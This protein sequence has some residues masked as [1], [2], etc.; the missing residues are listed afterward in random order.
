MFTVRVA[1]DEISAAHALPGY[2]GDC[3]RRHGHNWSFAAV[4]TASELHQDMVV[5][6]RIVKDVFRALDHTDLN[7]IPALNGPNCRPTA[8][9][10]A[11]YLA[12]RLE[13]VL[14]PLPNHPTLLAL[15]V[16]ETSRN[17]VTYQPDGA[18][19]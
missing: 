16:R 3:A 13:G 11:Q 6:F 14:A 8:E 10:L 2:P 1:I 18:R 12:Q 5:D 7:D 4:I 15:T 9:R 19:G 17:E